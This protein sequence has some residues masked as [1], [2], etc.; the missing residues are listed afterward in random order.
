MKRSGPSLHCIADNLFSAH[1]LLGAVKASFDTQ[2]NNP[3]PHGFPRYNHYWQDTFDPCE[4]GAST[5]TGIMQIVRTHW[6]DFFSGLDQYQQIA[7]FDTC[8]WDSIAWNWTILIRNGKYIHDIYLPAKFQQQQ[9]LFP[10][11]CPF[12]DCDTFPSK[13]NKEDLKTY[14]YTVGFP[15]MQQI[16]T[17]K[18]WF[19]AIGDTIPPIS[20]AAKY[21]R[22]VRKYT[23]RRPWR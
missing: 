8:S 9:T 15:T 20:K 23:Y 22:D 3:H 1:Y 16:L 12:A 21:V 13:K 14:G 18:Q 2:Q 19:N 4:N 5:A 6:D 11:S 7:G 17:D 10:D